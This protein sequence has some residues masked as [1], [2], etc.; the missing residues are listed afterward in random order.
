M[1]TH[2]RTQRLGLYSKLSNES[3]PDSI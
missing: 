2:T 1:Q 3:T